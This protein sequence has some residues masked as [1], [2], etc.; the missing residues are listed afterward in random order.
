MIKYFIPISFVFSILILISC[1]Q[2]ENSENQEA[3]VSEVNTSG[4][5]APKKQVPYPE[6][7]TDMQ[8]PVID[9]A[10]ILNK[11][12]L[13]NTKN[14][15]GM[16]VWE[17][18]D[19]SFEDVKAFYLD[20]LEKNGWERKTD[21]DKQS[22][23]EHERGDAPVKYFVTKFHKQIQG[24]KKRFILLINVTSGNEGT[25]TVIKILKEM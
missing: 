14:K 7:F 25:T 11:K 8:I 3:Q 22:S 16:Q 21:A 17:R 9:G 1:S 15:I 24:G 4:N 5:Q 18:S 6:V 23:P 2:S 19:K 10:Y 12:K 13:T 20:D